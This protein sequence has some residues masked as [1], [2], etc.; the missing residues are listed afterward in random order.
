MQTIY[1]IVDELI[2]YAQKNLGLDARNEVYARNAVLN[3]LGIS[4]YG[5]KSDAVS[6]ALT[7]EDIL[8]RLKNECVSDRKSVV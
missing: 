4:S 2:D 7:P 8:L 3:A 1:R 6:S 5:E